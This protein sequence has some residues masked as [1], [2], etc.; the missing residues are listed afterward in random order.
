MVWFV[1]SIVLGAIG[2]GGMIFGPQRI[3]KVGIPLAAGFAWIILSLALSLHTVGQREVG[4]VKSFSGTIGDHTKAPGVVFTAPWNHI[5]KENVGIQKEIFDFSG[6]NAA[7]TKDQQSLGATLAVNF[8][9]EPKDVV[10]LYRTVGPTWKTVLLD[11]RIPQAFKETT[12]Q[13]P[14]AA[15]TL[16]RPALRK[17]TLERLRHELGRYDIRV[18]D[19]FVSNIKYS[20]SYEAAI[21]AK[22]H[23]QQAA[24]TAQAKIVQSTAEANQRIQTAEGEAK[25]IALEGKAL[26]D[27]PEVLRLRA[28]NR[29]AAKA[30]VVYCSNGDCP[31]FLGGLVPG[32]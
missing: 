10:E 24:L 5:Q 13:F 6:D 12:A 7:V 26:H 3:Y 30:T 14:S 9:V 20:A 31:S 11:G 32:K 4:L 22:L 8:Q 21:E 15:I 27:H 18:V 16:K 29:L 25:A 19:V 17:I 28:I 2:I 1:L 23:Q